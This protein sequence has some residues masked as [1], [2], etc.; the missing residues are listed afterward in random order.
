MVTNQI[1][2]SGPNA[3]P[4][5]AVPNRWTRNSKSKIVAV[6]ATVYFAKA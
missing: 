5:F 3:L 1:A 4:T 6:I 2:I